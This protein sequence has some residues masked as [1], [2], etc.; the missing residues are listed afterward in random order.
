M[1]LASESAGHESS[2]THVQIRF[3]QQDPLIEA[4]PSATCGFCGSSGCCGLCG[5]P[6]D[7]APPG[8]SLRAF[9]HRWSAM[10]EP[11][12][13]PKAGGGRVEWRRREPDDSR[14]RRKRLNCKRLG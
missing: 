11:D 1:R 8:A 7:S 13:S 14:L 5:E 6:F 9:S 12:G 2:R 10:S 4:D 3:V